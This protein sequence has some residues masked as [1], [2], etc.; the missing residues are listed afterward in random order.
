M[1]AKLKQLNEDCKKKDKIIENLKKMGQALKS[2]AKE[3]VQKYENLKEEL[4]S[5][6]KIIQ[7]DQDAEP[8]D[9][10]KEV[11]NLKNDNERGKRMH[12]ISKKSTYLAHV[13]F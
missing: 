2:E 13:Q 10:A 6:K 11:Q 5:V 12:G 8:I 4:N 1:A 3:K 7:T 9:L